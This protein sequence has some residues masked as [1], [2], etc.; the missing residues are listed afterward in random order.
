[1]TLTKLSCK[2]VHPKKYTIKCARYNVISKKRLTWECTKKSNIKWRSYPMT[3][4]KTHVCTQV[5]NKLK[6]SVPCKQWKKNVVLL[7]D[8]SDPNTIYLA[9]HT[10]TTFKYSESSSNLNYL[11]TVDRHI[12]KYT[13]QHVFGLSTEAMVGIGLAGYMLSKVIGGIQNT[14]YHSYSKKIE[15]AKKSFRISVN[16]FLVDENKNKFRQSTEIT[17]TK[18]QRLFRAARISMWGNIDYT[19]EGM[20]YKSDII[21][22]QQRKYEKEVLAESMRVQDLMDTYI[23]KVDPLV[24]N[25]QHGLSPHYTYLKSVNMKNLKDMLHR[26]TIATQVIDAIASDVRKLKHHVAEYSEV[27]SKR[28][29]ELLSTIERLEKTSK[30][31]QKNAGYWS[32]NIK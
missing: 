30:K 20:V 11:N 21:K 28:V 9:T 17:L 23:E 26:Y 22:A 12:V 7:S 6:L 2:T 4:T 8:S 32:K 1:M 31:H 19:Y 10:K 16:E 13:K 14:A 27:R 5:Y 29:S 3:N 24:Q 18:L 15:K 25:I